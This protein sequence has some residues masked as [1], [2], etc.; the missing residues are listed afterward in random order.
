MD[1]H[2]RYLA[3]LTDEPDR[4]A[5]YYAT[6]FGLRELGRSD[7]GDVS[8]TD[9]VFHVSFLK[10]RS[11]LGE[12]DDRLGLHHFGVAVDDVR[13]LERRLEEAA[14]DMHLISENGDPHHG[15]YRVID[16]D[17]LPI[18][19]STSGF[20]VTATPRDYP[21]LRHA[22]IKVANPDGVVRRYAAIFGF[23]EASS[24]V[25][26]RE[27]GKAT[28]YVG[29]GETN[30]AILGAAN[31]AAEAD[32]PGNVSKLGFNHFGFLVLSLQEM[33]GRLPSDADTS[34]RP[35]GHMMAE[36][37]T[38]DPDGNGVDISSQAGWEVDVER[39]ARVEAPLMANQGG[40]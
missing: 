38:F 6:N 29:D 19:I 17:G 35:D 10:R 30:L 26:Q 5:R 12:V 15:Q 9:G 27:R 34:K 28:C 31:V 20:G 7:A 4:L 11:D 24:S 21:Q 8:M 39:W 33:L 22:A 25:R 36:F 13:Q 23:R 14:P 37:R 3:M 40:R 1:A 16:P 2:I 18:S 32:A